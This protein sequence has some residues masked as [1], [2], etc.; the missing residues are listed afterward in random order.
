MSAKNSFDEDE[1]NPFELLEMMG[2]Q[3]ADQ[4]DDEDDE[5]DEDEDEDEDEEWDENLY[6]LR[7]WML[8]S[9]FGDWGGYANGLEWDGS[10]DLSDQ[11]EAA[12]VSLFE[13][14]RLVMDMRGAERAESKLS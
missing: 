9:S 3:L 2:W 14:V 8:A 1:D 6:F 11:C 12:D 5:D 7:Q 13:H 4:E 10:R